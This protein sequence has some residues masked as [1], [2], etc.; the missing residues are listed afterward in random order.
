[1][2]RSARKVEI[3]HLFTHLD[4]IYFPEDKM[5][6]GDVIHYYEKIAPFILPY[7]KD[8]P[9]SLKRFPNGIE[10]ESFFQKNLQYYPD[11]IQT[12]EIEHAQG[13]KRVNYLLIQDVDSLLFAVNMG[14]IELHPFLSKVG[15][16]ENPDYIILDLDPEGISFDKVVE[17]A[18]SIH[19]IL[20]EIEIPGY[21]KTSGATGMHIYIPLKAKYSYDQAKQFGELI[22]VLAHERNPSF[23]SLERDPKKRQ[24]KVYIDFLQNR[25]RQTVIAP[26][27][28]R[29]RAGAPVSTPLE[30]SEVKKG[31]DPLDFTMDVIFKRLEKMGDIFNPV[32]KGGINLE[33][34]LKKI[35]KLV[36]VKG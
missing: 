18:L 23:T 33:K 13:K 12:I 34:A 14:C 17:A 11:W 24:K 30:W 27:S 26:Y 2:S 28:L 32:L 3:T 29:A 9:E 16:L 6:K 8:R 20:E 5:I 15:S 4:K 21:C 35:D 36:H 1:M 22:A 31:I 19:E 7:L 25:T 10:G